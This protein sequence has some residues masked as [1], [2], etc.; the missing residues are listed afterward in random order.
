MYK[1]QL[2]ILI[3]FC[4]LV[5][6]SL[7]AQ[8][9]SNE[10]YPSLLWE[11]TGNGL[12]KPSYLFGTMHVSSKLVFHLSDSFYNAIKKT[13]AV[14]LELN[15][16]VWQGQ[17]VKLDKLKEN[18]ASFVQ[19]AG[20]DYLTEN[21]FRIKKY[22]DELKL[23]LQTEP[24]IV[25]NLLY[26]SYK[27]KEDF[28]EDT[29]LDLYIFQTGR[30]LGK[31]AAGVENYYEAE[32]LILE[33]YADMA[34]EKKKKDNDLDAEFM[35]DYVE[36][37]QDAYRKGDLDLMDSLDNLTEQSA[38]FRE[39]FLYKRN[40]IQAN[41]IDSIIK[42]TSLF[43]GVGAAHLPGKR[44]VIELLRKKGYT[45]KPV[46]MVDRNGLQKNAIDLLRVPVVFQ[47]KQSDDKFYSVD[48]PGDLYKVR[49]DFQNLDRRQYADM[50]NGSY[51]LVTR[52][53]TYAAFLGQPEK[54]VLKKVDSVLY[55]NIPG[56]I[57]SKKLIIKN[58]YEGYDIS[59][60][61]RRGDLQRYQIFVTPFEIIIFKMSG[62][63]NYV[64]G[65]E[66]TQFFSSISLKEKESKPVY[67]QPA[68]GGFAIRLPQ[69]P[70][71]YLNNT[72][73]DERWEYEATDRT[74][75]DAWLI[76]KKCIYNFNFIEED[77]FD[78]GL[79]EES[80]RSPEFFDKQISRKQTSF[81]GFPVLEVK[82]KLKNGS[83]V[84]ARFFINGPHYYVVAHRSNTDKLPDDQLNSF[85]FK[86]FN[87]PA[88][89][90]YTDTFLRASVMT[91]VAPEMDED[92][93][94]LIE[95]NL[96][97][98][99]NGNNYTGYIS[100]WQKPKNGIF[101]S[102]ATGEAIAVHVQ[103]FPK[104]FY[105]KDSSKY[106]QNEIAASF[107]RHDM[108]LYGKVNYLKEND[109]SG[110]RFTLRDTGSSRT[111]DQ[112]LLIKNNFMYRV[113]TVGDTI[114]GTG[115]F[116]KTFFDTFRPLQNS[117]FKNI[118]ENRL[119]LFFDDLFSTDS[120]LQKKAQQSVGN[121]Q[122]G[123]PG[124]PLVMNAINRLS[125][126]DKDYYN[127]K[128]KL[129][130]ELGYI[131][132]STSDI[133]VSHLKTIYERTAD[134][135]LFQNEVIKALAR[136]KTKAS[137]D[138]LKEFFLHDPPIFES[139]YDYNS[140]FNNLQDSLELSATL[141]PEL[142]QLASLDDYKEKILELLVSLVDS[143]YAKQDKY[144]YYF[145]SIYIDAIVALKK[146][147]SKDEKLMQDAGKRSET[148]DPVRVYNYSNEESALYNYSTLLMPYY[149]KNKN[150]QNFFNRLLQSKDDDVKLNTVLLMLRNDKP[151]ADSLIVNLAAN[152][153]YCS[154]LF[155]DLEKINKL[156]RFPAQFKTQLNITRSSLVKQNEFDKLD[157]IVYLSRQPVM[158][159][160]KSGLVYFFK[161]R[162]KA[163]DQWR[164]GISGL[165]PENINMVSSDFSIVSMTDVKLKDNGLENEQLNVQLKK[166][167]FGLHKSGKNF[168]SGNDLYDEVK[169]IDEYED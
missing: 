126:H 168:Y 101:K 145:S 16:D 86:P 160:G 108:Y 112:L 146:Q 85:S 163:T 6:N 18:Y 55:E 144:D 161:Y 133:L 39:K 156:N 49:Q 117:P 35:N 132:D 44:G 22:A 45:L 159:K 97:A 155:Y 51:Y 153:R 130:N 113:S 80:F 37:I 65:N 167:L 109:F 111:L 143:G 154:T 114:T 102:E 83:F 17:M 78:L 141:F 42:H 63:E 25:N 100:Y 166:I 125:V 142:L 157:S 138:Q 149:E 95:Q 75:G 38:A 57:L 66:A 19:Q 165:Q 140:I 94:S 46:K 92:I 124:I 87:Y 2:S 9:K 84:N 20:N 139:N 36:K 127:T 82:E 47:K 67:F 150:V 151:V 107:N 28:E 13:D 152:D 118:Y 59:S 15:P 33:A 116:S 12:A 54:E 53:K 96:D 50:S 110:V 119:S 91:P 136:L 79:V 135:S 137:F 158:V 43:A 60:K 77:S 99:A 4:S 129:I 21:S 71:E 31:K 10:K 30:K 69:M 58:G 73:T 148:D 24:A 93:R 29:F 1:K 120:A 76:F 147:K 162:I 74:T 104:Y 3:V 70:D 121:V 106:W 41:A 34:K 72:T 105:I 5:A 56:K 122:Y 64:S 89:K 61:T 32:K 103:E 11:I 128:S 26:R 62:K 8:E 164:I 14:A 90:L 7:L 68:Q 23:A 169:A 131:K 98:V 40:E 88:S 81:N 123:T 52:V 27:A 115:D 48:V 134:T